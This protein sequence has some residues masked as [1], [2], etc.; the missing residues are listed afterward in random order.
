MKAPDVLLS[1]DHGRI[2]AWRREQR[3]AR[4]LARRPDLIGRDRADGPEEGEEGPKP[5]QPPGETR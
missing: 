5:K 4:T 1:G 2:A 3:I